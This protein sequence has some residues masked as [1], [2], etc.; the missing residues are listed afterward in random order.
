MISHSYCFCGPPLGEGA[1]SCGGYG[2][3]LKLEIFK[4]IAFTLNQPSPTKE[5]AKIAKS[6]TVMVV[7]HQ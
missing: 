6:Q 2:L 3:Y 5:L 7:C 1:L 4:F